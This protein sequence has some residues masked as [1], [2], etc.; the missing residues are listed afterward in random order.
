[1]TTRV[2]ELNR[3]ILDG[4]IEIERESDPLLLISQVPWV[5]LHSKDEPSLHYLEHGPT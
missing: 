3:R 4:N 5:E 2:S 1:M